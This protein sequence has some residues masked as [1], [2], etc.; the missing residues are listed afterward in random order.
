MKQFGELVQ[1]NVI[2]VCVYLR[3]RIAIVIDIENVDTVTSEQ[4]C[5]KITNCEE[6]GLNQ[7]LCSNVFSLW[8]I[9]PLLEL[10]LKPTDKPYNLRKSWRYFLEQYSHTSYNKQIRDEP[11]LVFQRNV[12]FSPYLEEKIKDHKLIE[13]LYEEAQYNILHGRYPCEEMHYIMLGSIQARIE[14]GPYNPQQ[15]SIRF[16]RQQVKFIPMHIRKSWTWKWLP[17]SSK[18]SIEVKLLEQFKRIPNVTTNR[19]LMRKY[20]EFC[21]SLPFYGSAFFEGQ[22]EQPVTG[23]I[24]LMTHQ[25]QPVLVGINSKGLYII[26]DI[27]CVLLLGLKF[28]EFSWEY[29]RPSKEDDLNCL[30][31]IFIQFTIIENGTSVS[32]ILQIFSRQA[33]LMDA[34][35]TTFNE[36]FKL[37]IPDEVNKPLEQLHMEKDSH[38]SFIMYPSNLPW[39]NNKL[40]KLTLATFDEEGRCIGQ[41]GSWT[42]SY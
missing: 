5:E 10:Q 20:L 34:L 16:F 42:L 2:P 33:S 22:I 11:R 32:K 18:N 27:K 39:L 23:L 17:I 38:S 8:M 29:A 9:S 21:W 25:D 19:K 31:C 26:D 13:L 3:N 6:L 24:S 12:F 15:H 37:K 1:G 40:N 28:E 30:P 35:I 41:M 36:Q 14:L 4:I 7:Q